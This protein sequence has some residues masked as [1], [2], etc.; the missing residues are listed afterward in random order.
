MFIDTHCHIKSDNAKEY[1]NNA[2]NADVHV[3]IN[4]SEDL[5]SSFKVSRG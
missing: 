2:I 1:V 5:K 4:A 3:M